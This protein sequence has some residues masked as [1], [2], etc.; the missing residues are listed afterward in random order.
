VKLDTTT[1]EAT[2]QFRSGAGQMA[3]GA[4]VMA[5]GVL[6]VAAGVKLANISGEFEMAMTK[7]G[8]ISQASAADMELLREAALQ[9]GTAFKPTESAKALENLA[10]QGFNAQESIK[11]LPGVLNLAQGGMIS[12]D[13]SSNAVSAAIKVFSLTAD[14]AVSVA[15]KMLKISNTTSLAAGDMEL[16]MGAVARGASAAGQNLDEMLVAMGLVKNTGVEVSVAATAVSSALQYVASKASSFK[17]LG[18]AV[19][20]SKGQFRNFVDIV[21]DTQKVLGKIPDAAKR[22]AQATELFSRFGVSAYQA[23]STQL[24]AG[25]RDAN[26]QL[27]QG[28]AALAEMRRQMKE[29]GGTSQEFS[30]KMANTLEGQ[31]SILGAAKQ[32]LLTVLG[33]GFAFALKP[34]VMWMAAGMDKLKELINRIPADTRTKLAKVALG[35]GAVI[36]ALGGLLAAKAG[37]ALFILTLKLL[38]VTIGG[39]LAPLLPVAAALGVIIL[40]VKG[41][42]AA[43]GNSSSGVLDWLKEVGAKL[44]L[45]A[46]AMMQLFSEGGFSGRVRKELNAAGNGGVKDFAITVFM[47]VA[48]IKNFFSGLADGFAA[49]AATMRPIWEA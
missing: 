15:D 18:V 8:A 34:L 27:L 24:A 33:E 19:T 23:I 20:D 40:L 37:I 6:T 14:D 26:G 4:G 22:T 41:F 3:V 16:A 12:L 47:W 31:E 32:R 13:Q 48:R 7:V 1:K 2:E 17:A 42:Q 30:D 44:W 28:S 9:S 36:A 25:V 39:I 38:G 10:A 45:F 5:A 21:Q 11:G 29:A 46:E 49:T 43:M 35:V